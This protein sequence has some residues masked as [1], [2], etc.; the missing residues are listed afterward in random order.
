MT[1]LDLLTLA[2]RVEAAVGLC[3]DVIDNLPCDHCG[4]ITLRGCIIPVAERKAAGDLI[5]STSGLM[6]ILRCHSRAAM[7]QEK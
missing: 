4:S 3:G 6:N 2:E 1:A 7:S 5:N